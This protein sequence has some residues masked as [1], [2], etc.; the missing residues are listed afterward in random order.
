MACWSCNRR[1]VACSFSSKQSNAA[2]APRPRRGTS[3][4]HPAPAPPKRLVPVVLIPPFDHR[5]NAEANRQ[6][7]KATS[8]DAELVDTLKKRVDGFESFMRGALAENET[9]LNTIASDNA[10]VEG[11]MGG[12][13][14]PPVGN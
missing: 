6:K 2:K 8:S 3:S 11:L 5:A 1:K 12:G 14:P 10:V 9:R 13:V 4:R 7:L